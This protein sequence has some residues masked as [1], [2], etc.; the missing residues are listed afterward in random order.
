VIFGSIQSLNDGC[1]CCWRSKSQVQS[2]TRFRTPPAGPGWHQYES[3]AIRIL[4][5]I[6]WIDPLFRPQYFGIIFT[7]TTLHHHLRGTA[8][9]S[10]PTVGLCYTRYMFSFRL[11]VERPSSCSPHEIQRETL[12]RNKIHLLLLLVPRAIVLLSSDNA[13]RFLNRDTQ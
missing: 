1:E 6:T 3:R 13:T 8:F 4:A 2:K 5:K 9:R 7:S 12:R 10:I 11:L